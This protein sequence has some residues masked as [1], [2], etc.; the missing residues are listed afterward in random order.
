[1]SIHI[2]STYQI[3]IYQ[4][5]KKTTQNNNKQQKNNSLKQ[6]TNKDQNKGEST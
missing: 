2:T 6:Q 4:N 5:L 1:M 3:S